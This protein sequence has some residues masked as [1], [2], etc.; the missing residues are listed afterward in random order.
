MQKSHIYMYQW[1]SRVALIVRFCFTLQGCLQ[2]ADIVFLVDGSGS[3]GSGNF[4]KLENFVKGIVG[5]LDVGADTVHVG[6]VQFSNYPKQ[7][8]PLNMYTTRQDVM[9]GNVF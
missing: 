2:Q 7:E 5:K 3:I 4:L 1:L 9:A 8:F 6:V